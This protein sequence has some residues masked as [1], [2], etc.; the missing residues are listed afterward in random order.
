MQSETLTREILA[1]AETPAAVFFVELAHVDGD[2]PAVGSVYARKANAV[3][4]EV[5]SQVLATNDELSALWASPSGAVWVASANG[6]IATTAS[7][8]WQPAHQRTYTSKDPSVPWSVTSLPPVR[9]TGL[10][11]NV[12]SLWGT[13]DAHVF[14]GTYSGDIFVWDGARWAP[15]HEGHSLEAHSHEGQASIR[16]F[17]GIRA[18]EV[19][20]V[21]QH[22]TLL[23][24]D[25]TGWRPLAVAGEPNGREHF[26]AVHVSPDGDVLIAGTGGH[27]RLV[28]GRAPDLVELTRTTLSLIDMVVLDGR[29]LLATGDGVAE[30]FEKDI[31]V[32][33]DNFMTATAWSGRGRVFFVEPAQ[34]VPSFIEHDPRSAERPWV[35]RKY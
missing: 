16:A 9:A 22:A 30:L 26:T 11:P 20:A 5:P 24:F 28:H 25:G 8:S 27:G 34:T 13:D 14:A 35:R 23:R 29:V 31:R 10:P 1:L 12:T 17:G 18:D 7:V 32:V 6:L 4:G 19:F 3:G 15:S 2:S 21:G 33:K